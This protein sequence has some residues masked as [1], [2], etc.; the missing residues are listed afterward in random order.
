MNKTLLADGTLLFV[1]FVWGA[2]FVVVQDAIAFL[3]PFSFNAVRFFMAFVLL[4]L[5]YVF[6][7]KKQANHFSKTSIKAGITLGF[8][9]FLSYAFQT[10]GLLYTSP[11]KAGFI[12]GLSV[13]L[14]PLFSFLLLKQKLSRNA[15]LGVIC[16]TVGLYMI[17]ML[18]A[19]SVNKGDFFVLI[20]A[21]SF[22]MHIITTGKYAKHVQALPLT[23]IQIFSVAL[24]S[25]I[26]SFIF[27][28]PQAMYRAEVLLKKEVLSGLLITSILA[29]AF[30]F[31]A[32]TY[33]QAYTSATRVALIF[34]MEPVFAALTSYIVIGEQF[35]IS[36]IFG[37]LLILMGNVLAEWPTKKM[38]IENHSL[39][40]AG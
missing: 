20:S 18:Q 12:T 34:A 1:V 35:T 6:F 5:F 8:W 13:I 26:S 24:L 2:T 33:F 31:L 28:N 25:F 22:A 32:Q 14:V 15:L 27:E 23:I 37:C 17:T 7:S 36:M 30:A 21:I 38:S 4:A 40:K 19:S 3:T 10:L 11:A 29:T 39:K 9:L 16:A